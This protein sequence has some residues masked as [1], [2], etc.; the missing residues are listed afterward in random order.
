M[1]ARR[2]GQQIR[3]RRSSLGIG[4]EA[5]CAKADVSRGVLSKLESGRG[6]PVQTDV[7][8]RLAAGLGMKLTVNLGESASGRAEE[9]LRQALRRA[10]LRER[11]LRIALELCAD[12]KRARADLRR[13]LQQVDLWERKKSC[14]PSYI[15][16][17]RAALAGSP[18]QAALAM[19]SF[20]EWENAMYQNSPWSFRWS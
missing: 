13:A 2:L 1:L 16:G 17:W 9:R 19:T 7:I 10:E 14:S 18:R 3:D 11:H 6:A 12:P 8:D 20:G 15:D 4:Q 5:L